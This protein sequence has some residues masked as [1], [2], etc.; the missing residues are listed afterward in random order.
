MLIAQMPPST[1]P[2]VLMVASDAAITER[3]GSSTNRLKALGWT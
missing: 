3:I 2:S 1:M